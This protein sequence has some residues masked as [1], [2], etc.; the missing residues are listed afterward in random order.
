MILVSVSVLISCAQMTLKQVEKL[1][2]GMTV[3]ESRM[4]TTVPPI[5]SF[6]LDTIQA[7]STLKVDS[8]VL[9]SG[10]YESNYFLAY[11]NRELIFW[12]YPHEFA[13]SKD[14]LLNE[15]GR[16]AVSRLEQLESR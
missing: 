12:G 16:E 3:E 9:K 13:R 6:L 11:R 4:V 8:Y 14:P 10:Q 15:I 1:R 5:H 2:I 7:E